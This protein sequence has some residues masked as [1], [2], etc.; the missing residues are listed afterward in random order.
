MKPLKFVAEKTEKHWLCACRQSDSLPF[1][2]GQHRKEKGLKKYNEFLLKKNT[3]LKEEQKKLV[4]K[5]AVGALTGLSAGLLLA[6]F[7][8]KKN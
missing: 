1:C 3:E 4:I 2:D 7:L 8:L 5:G 6:Y